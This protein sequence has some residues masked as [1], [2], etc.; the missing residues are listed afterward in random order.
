MISR[1]A[2]FFILE[3]V[4]RRRASRS[5]PQRLALHMEGPAGAGSAGPPGRWPPRAR[6]RPRSASLGA[7]LRAQRRAGRRARPLPGSWAAKGRGQ[8]RV[9]RPQLPL[10]APGA[11]PS[12]G[13]SRRGLPSR[14][15]GVRV[16]PT[17]TSDARTR[18]RERPRSRGGPGL[19]VAVPACATLRPAHRAWL[20][21]ACPCG[22]RHI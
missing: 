16:P 1:N 8:W 20:W 7:Q 11:P 22:P 21:R 5:V 6:P 13:I 2:E 15:P 10:S 12:P 18:G 14:V 9:F 3:T 17:R 4:E 19:A